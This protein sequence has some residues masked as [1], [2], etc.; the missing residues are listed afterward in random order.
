[1]D[2]VVAKAYCHTNSSIDLLLFCNTEIAIHHIHG[3]V[4]IDFKTTR[5]LDT[6]TIMTKLQ[7]ARVDNIDE[8]LYIPQGKSLGSLH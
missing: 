6:F 1:M 2:D 5:I 7:K 4:T 8:T 3:R